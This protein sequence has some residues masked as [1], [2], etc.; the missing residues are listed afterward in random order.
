M[1]KWLR[2]L[3]CRHHWELCRKV[4]GYSSLRGE[5]LYR[6]CTKC[7]KVVKDIYREFEGMGYK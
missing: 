3:V 6:R 5:Q 2:R 7:G 1:L 4:G